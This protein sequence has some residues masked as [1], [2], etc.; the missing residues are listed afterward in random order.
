MTDSEKRIPTIK[1]GDTVAY[2]ETFLHSIGQEFD[3]V[4]RARG[5]VTAL[6]TVH[7]ELTMAEIDWDAPYLPKR[8]D[9]KHLIATSAM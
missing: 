4:K 7:K 5:R 9:I 3:N 2:S 6:I 1:V 8:V